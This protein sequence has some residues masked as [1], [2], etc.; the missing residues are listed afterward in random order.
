[1]K[2]R[3]ITA[4][5]L[6]PLLLLVVLFAPHIVTAAL[7]GILSSV[8]AY[9]LIKSTGY[10]DS[11]RLTAYSMVMA[12]CVSLISYFGWNEIRFLAV[13]LLFT[14]L[15]F[16]EIMISDMRIDFKNAFI[17]FAAGFLFPYLLSALNRIHIMDNGRFYILI[18]F[19][20]AFLSD[21]G[22]Y[23]TG[24][25]IG[26]HKLAPKISPKKTIEGVVGGI[27]FAIAGML[28]YCVVL[29]K[30]FSFTTNYLYAVIY[31]ALGSVAAVFGDL[32]L[33]VI[34][35]Q[36]GI[37]DYGKLFPGHGGV[38]DRFDS[39]LIVAPLAEFLLTILPLAV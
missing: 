1:M 32:C 15:I 19:V 3:I 17:C 4:V 36:T 22:A 12:L 11:K 20:I 33:S 5:I 8:G 10:L 31:G 34:K 7:F 2:T 18:P 37:K 13:I 26:K 6:L 25:A 23:F 30:A 38:L 27:V 24:I 14:V 21:T 29:Q 35:R 39:M 28:I 9:E 16:S